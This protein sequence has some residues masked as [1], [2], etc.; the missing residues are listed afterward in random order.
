MFIFSPFDSIYEPAKKVQ[1]LSGRI[2]ELFGFY[3]FFSRAN[4]FEQIQQQQLK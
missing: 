1:I 3:T 4:L 2:V